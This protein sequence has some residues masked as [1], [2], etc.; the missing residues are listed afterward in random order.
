MLKHQHILLI[1]SVKSKRD[2]KHPARH[3]WLFGQGADVVDLILVPWHLFVSKDLF[4]C[5][6]G[7]VIA[8]D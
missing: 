5:N 8:T 7:L 1:W 2:K 6:R 3:H 4:H